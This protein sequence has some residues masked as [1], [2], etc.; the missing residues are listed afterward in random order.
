MILHGIAPLE[1]LYK[2]T[3]SLIDDVMNKFRYIVALRLDKKVMYNADGL[4]FVSEA[5]KDYF[6]KKY[7]FIRSKKLYTT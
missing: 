3:N 7:A 4:I 1:F 6:E 2:Q 5:M